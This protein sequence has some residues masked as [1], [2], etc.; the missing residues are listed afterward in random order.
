MRFDMRTET[1]STDSLEDTVFAHRI[2]LNLVVGTGNQCH[3]VNNDSAFPRV[4]PDRCLSY[5]VTRLHS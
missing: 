4:S 3:V 2:E 1:V 5:R